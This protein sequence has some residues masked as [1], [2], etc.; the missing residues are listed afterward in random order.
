METQNQIKRTLSQPES[1]EYIINLLDT[2][3]NIIR[4]KLADQLCEH[5]GFFDPRG[6]NSAPDALRHYGNWNRMG[7]LIYR[8][9]HLNWVKEVQDV[10]PSQ[11]LHRKKCLKLDRYGDC[12]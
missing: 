2:K 4:T 6:N 10:L 11:Y 9:L 8:N 5:F 1:I 3:N 7:G 12:A